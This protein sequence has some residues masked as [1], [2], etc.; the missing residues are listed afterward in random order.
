MQQLK[1]NGKRLEAIFARLWKDVKNYCLAV[2]FFLIYAAV[3][4]FLFGTICPLA[5]M[6]GFPCP[7]CGSTRA[8]FLILTGRFVEAFRYNPCIYLWILLAVYVGWQ[9]YIR[10]RRAVGALPMAGGIAAAMILIYLYRLAVEF[11]GSPPMVY[12]TDNV[13]AGLIPAYDELMRRLFSG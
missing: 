11:P 4:T 7:G 2:A 10:G 8:L 5:A 3:V 9:R 1:D 13:L 6:T 12:R